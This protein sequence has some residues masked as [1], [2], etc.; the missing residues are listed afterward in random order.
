MLVTL[1]GIVMLVRLGLS[2]NAE[3]PMRV[4]GRPLIVPGM[5]TAPSEPVYAVMVIAPALVVK[6]NWAT[7][8]ADNSALESQAGP[9]TSYPPANSTFPLGSK[10]A[11]CVDRATLRE[12]LAFHVP[13]RSEE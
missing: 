8:A 9:L 3:S 13:V 12:P 5:A 2:M 4:T 1:L 11:T 7:C 10:V 6:Q